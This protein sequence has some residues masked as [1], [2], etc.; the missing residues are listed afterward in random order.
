MQS[1]YHLA[2]T[3]GKLDNVMVTTNN[4]PFEKER[5]RLATPQLKQRTNSQE[6][7]DVE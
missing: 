2:Y 6:Q 5:Y 1:I 4:E 7:A 3:V